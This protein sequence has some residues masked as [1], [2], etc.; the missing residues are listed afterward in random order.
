MMSKE[1]SGRSTLPNII[2]TSIYL[3]SDACAQGVC[4]PTRWDGDGRGGKRSNNNPNTPEP[5]KSASWERRRQKSVHRTVLAFFLETLE[6]GKQESDKQGQSVWHL[7][8]KT[9]VVDTNVDALCTAYT[10]Y[11][12]QTLIYYHCTLFF[13]TFTSCRVHYYFF[14][15]NASTSDHMR[16]REKRGWGTSTGKIDQIGDLSAIIKGIFVIN[17]HA[18][19]GGECKSQLHFEY[20]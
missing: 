13:F 16:I 17:R 7:Q 10:C 3:V 5:A 6:T 18:F 1:K 15:V 9:A 11:I 2:I 8:R 4:R 20:E 12:K 19:I 14:P